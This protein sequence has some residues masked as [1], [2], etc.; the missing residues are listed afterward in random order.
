M[1]LRSLPYIQV[2]RNVLPNRAKLELSEENTVPELLFLFCLA[3]AQKNHCQDGR[4]LR[5]VHVCEK[6]LCRHMV[7]YQWYLTIFGDSV[8]FR[9][10]DRGKCLF[11]CLQHISRQQSCNPCTISGICFALSNET[12]KKVDGGQM[13][14]KVAPHCSCGR[15]AEGSS[16]TD[17][18]GRDV[19]PRFCQNIPG[20]SGSD[21]ANKRTCRAVLEPHL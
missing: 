11:W 21:P 10:R 7:L 4:V 19:A 8:S 12:W 3:G 5:H 20:F 17:A 2:L 1:N 18:C 9:G 14:Q 15:F 16:S 13:N 6:Q